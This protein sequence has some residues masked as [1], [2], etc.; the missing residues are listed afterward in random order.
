MSGGTR[1]TVL[2]GASIGLCTLWLVAAGAKLL[3]PLTA[4]EL[5][6][7]VLGGGPA[8]KVV[9]TLVLAVETLLGGLIL[10]RVTR[11][12]LPSMAVLAFFAVALKLVEAKAT[13]EVPCGCL[14]SILD[15][16]V[17]QEFWFDVV[18]FAVLAA[19]TVWDLSARRTARGG[20]AAP[21]PATT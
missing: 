3:E 6:T 18:L 17:Q 12:F 8:P 9:L 1:E 2:R 13:A 10:F 11:S 15:V 16:T 5:V 19:L 21:G 4:Y 20:A 14:P 7:L